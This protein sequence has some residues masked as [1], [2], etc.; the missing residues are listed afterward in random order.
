MHAPRPPHPSRVPALAAAV[1][2]SFAA[3]GCASAPR[4]PAAFASSEV[5]RVRDLKSASEATASSGTSTVEGAVA[6]VLLAGA[7]GGM[8]YC[9]YACA[10]PWDAAVPIGGGAVILTTLVVGAFVWAGSLGVV[11]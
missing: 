5:V 1:L 7:I 2:V 11:R 4:A 9:A 10:E 8:G 6:G 3:Q